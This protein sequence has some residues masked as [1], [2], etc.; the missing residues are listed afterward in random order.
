MAALNRRVE[1]ESFATFL[2]V[3]CNA[4]MTISAGLEPIAMSLKANVI[5]MFSAHRILLS[6]LNL[7]M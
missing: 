1:L 4:P 7:P 2:D 5:A 6:A 3:V